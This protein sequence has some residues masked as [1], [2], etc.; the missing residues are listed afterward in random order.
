M[1]DSEK[2]KQTT[3]NEDS[4]EIVHNSHKERMLLAW[5][6]RAFQGV[7]RS[8]YIMNNWTFFNNKIMIKFGTCQQ[9]RH[10]GIPGF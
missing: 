4:Q 1:L 9:T 2:I 7:R 10:L 6:E 3:D 5:E 8:V